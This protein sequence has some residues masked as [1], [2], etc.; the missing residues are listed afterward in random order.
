MVNLPIN[1]LQQE[2]DEVILNDDL[3]GAFECYNLLKGWLERSGLVKSQPGEYARYHDYLIKLKFL[4]L[5]FFDGVDDYYD[6]LKNYFPLSQDIKDF[7]LWSKL[8]TQL[9]YLSDLKERDAFKNKLKEALEKSD[10]LL[11]GHQKYSDETGMPH[12]VS[13]WIKDFVANLGLD[14]FDKLKKAEYLASGKYIKMLAEDEKNKVKNLLDIYEKLRISSRQ[15]NGYE[16][17]VVMNMDGKQF[18]FDHGEVEAISTNAINSVKEA[19]GQ[20][21]VIKDDL[22]LDK[23][24]QSSRPVA[25]PAPLSELAELEQTIGNYSPASLEFKA[26]KQE[27]SR[28]KAAAFKRAQKS[29][30]SQSDA[31][32]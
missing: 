2:I 24:A 19:K 11:I 25:T 21:G 31:K 8:E 5:N 3:N 1:L 23:P 4:S 15:P 7:D 26:V 27:I 30:G 6:L 28:L 14:D 13:E 22:F 32:K 12:K 10:S 20:S 29:V 18:I 17:T 9:V 16:N